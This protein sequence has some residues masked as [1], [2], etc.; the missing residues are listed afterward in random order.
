MSEVRGVSLS[1]NPNRSLWPRH[2]EDGKRRNTG[3]LLLVLAIGGAGRRGRV[4][5]QSVPPQTADGNRRRRTR[6]ELE[7]Y[8]G[9]EDGPPWDEDEDEKRDTE[10]GDEFHNKLF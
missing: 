5:F 8:D 3:M 9:E 2:A 1:R 10:D 4:L 6:Q 7:D